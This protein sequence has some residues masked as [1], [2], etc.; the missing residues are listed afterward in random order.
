M[1]KGERGDEAQSSAVMDGW[2]IVLVVRVLLWSIDGSGAKFEMAPKVRQ[3][4]IGS[5]WDREMAT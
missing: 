1:E 3:E 5:P 4:G 2:V